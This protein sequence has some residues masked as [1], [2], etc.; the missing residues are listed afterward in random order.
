MLRFRVLAT[1]WLSM[2]GALSGL[3]LSHKVFQRCMSLHTGSRDS[4]RPEIDV[5]GMLAF[6]G[7]A[8]CSELSAAARKS[9][10]KKDRI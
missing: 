3:V 7:K 1:L 6:G 9:R 4:Q 8:S 10:N 2:Y 5:Q